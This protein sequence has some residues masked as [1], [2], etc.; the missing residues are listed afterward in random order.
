MTRSRRQ[1]QSLIARSVEHS[2][3]PIDDGARVAKAVYARRPTS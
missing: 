1:I 3:A 2:A